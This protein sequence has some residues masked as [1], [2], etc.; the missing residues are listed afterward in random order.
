MKKHILIIGASSGIGIELTKMYLNDGY[1]IVGTYRNKI[2]ND[3]FQDNENLNL[4]HLD[5]SSI[6]S[7]NRFIIEYQNLSIKWDSLIS[8]PA[9][10]LP[11][12]NFFDVD[13]SEWEESVNINFIDQLRVIH[14]LYQ[15]RDM[16]KVVDIVFFGTA[17][18]NG[19]MDEMSAYAISKIGLLKMCEYLNSENK[20]I[21][22]F[23]IGT[24]WR[25]TKSHNMIMDS[26]E[27]NHPKYIQTKK[28]MDS[29]SGTDFQDIYDCINW[30]IKQGKEIS[31]GRNFSVVHDPWKEDNGQKLIEQL[32][33]DTELYKLKRHGNDW[34]K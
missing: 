3:T 25:K 26:L 6:D 29:Y 9:L 22:S 34:H 30:L 21:N 5:T 19:A 27:I 2:S 31:G 14:Q 32:K 11:I 1:K 12:K 4:I 8:C 17:G 33:N 28:F 24:G 13:F 18:V 16:T 7:V 20:D 10:P 23:I 15:L